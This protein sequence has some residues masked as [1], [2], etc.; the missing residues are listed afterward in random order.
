MEY[1]I[2]VNFSSDNEDAASALAYRIECMAVYVVEDVAV[3]VAE[4]D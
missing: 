3:T 2:T 1:M 4:T